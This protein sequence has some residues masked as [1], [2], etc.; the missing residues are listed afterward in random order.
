[1]VGWFE[2]GYAL[3]RFGLKLVIFAAF[4][5]SRSVAAGGAV[6]ALATLT[7]VSGF[8]DVA[9]ALYRLENPFEQRLTYWDE[10]AAFVALS[11]GLRWLS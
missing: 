10:A 8:V 2:I 11:I 5:V 9:L 4:A 1:M 3:R 6:G 7:M